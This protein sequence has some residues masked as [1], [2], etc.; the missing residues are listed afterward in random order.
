[1]ITT[2]SYKINIVFIINF[3]IV[4][5]SHIIKNNTVNNEKVYLEKS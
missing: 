3:K 4:I 2:D 5:Y 1:M